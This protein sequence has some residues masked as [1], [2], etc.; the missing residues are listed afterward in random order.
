MSSQEPSENQSDA[1]P[2]PEDAAPAASEETAAVT[3]EAAPV[4]EE[5]AEPAAEATP[6]AP[7][8]KPRP[9]P[10]PGG[11][12]APSPAV[13][14]AHAT[15]PV[16]VPVAS[17]VSDEEIAAA[18]AFG[19][20]SGEVV[21]VTD[22]GAKHEVGP[23]QG[24]EPLVPYVRAYFEL[25]ANVERF[26]ARLQAAELSPKDIDDSLDSLRASLLEPK[27][28]GDLAALRE[29]F[30]SVEAEAV[31][32]REAV[33]EQRRVA[34]KEALERREEIV[35]RAEAIANA[36]LETVHWK[37][38]TA[39]LRGLLDEWKEA[40]RSGARLPKDVERA[41]WKRFTHSR[42]SF[43]KARKHHFAE[44]D[45]ANA[46]VASSKEAL[47]ARAEALS[48]STDFDRG[49]REFRDLMTAWRNAGRGRRSVD[50]ALW[51]RFQAAQDAFFEA[52][53]T[54]ADAEEAALAP[55]IEA[56]EAAV[57]DAEALLPIK[58]LA[59]A[60]ASLRAAQD[61]FEAAGRLPRAESQALSR[62][63]GAV[64]RAVRDAESAAWNARNPEV[65][66]RV[67]GA[68]AQLHAA[69]A[70]L[71]EKLAAA[72]T[73]AEK[74]SLKEALDARKSWLKQ[75]AG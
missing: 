57:R 29:Q 23:A 62:R 37:N 11:F 17:D 34:R 63:L 75:I 22:G 2:T 66:A 9:V 47:V 6:A 44:V 8:A 36:P 52:R 65:E 19:N 35:A 5:D 69:I 10:R 42:T 25:K 50:D 54:N 56:A 38:D 74:K 32:A 21:S 43:E 71:E 60:K 33:A 40:Q 24:D 68:A 14:A 15:H 16:K 64:E 31:A 51:K 73:P 61:A 39:A 13:V 3:P 70:D 49:A 59:A 48:T 55:H 20:V 67:S 7:A 53:R 72:K 45:G 27:V 28:V 18:S 30:A 46:A 12:R 41:L 4:G 58:D 26:H 1:V